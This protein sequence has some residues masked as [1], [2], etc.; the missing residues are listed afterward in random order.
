[1]AIDKKYFYGAYGIDIEKAR[2]EIYDGMLIYMKDA[3]SI[4]NISKEIEKIV[5]MQKENHSK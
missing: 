5:L 1:M 3:Y 4:D 2:K